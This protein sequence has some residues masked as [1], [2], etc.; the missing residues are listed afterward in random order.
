MGVKKGQKVRFLGVFS[1][2][3]YKEMVVGE[4]S[5]K[6]LFLVG[7][8]FWRVENRFSRVFKGVGSKIRVWRGK[9]GF[10]EVQNEVYGNIWKKRGTF[11]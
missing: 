5:K 7:E 9:W 2:L 3:I 1:R 10:E 4:G 11:L 6:P 8:G